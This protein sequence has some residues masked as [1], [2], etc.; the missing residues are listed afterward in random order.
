MVSITTAE[1]FDS[2]P[3]SQGIPIPS[4]RL[5]CMWA[6]FG[7]SPGRY[8][9][10]RMSSGAR[11][12]T[13]TKEERHFRKMSSSRCLSSSTWYAFPS[14]TRIVRHSILPPLSLGGWRNNR[15]TSHSK[16]TIINIS[17]ICIFKAEF[18][19]KLSNFK[20]SENI[21][22]NKFPFSTTTA[23]TEQQ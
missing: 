4:I 10:H 14:H 8:N 2:P 7:A 1:L 20:Q 19:H 11:G 6:Y 16:D 18:N 5:H 12:G 13:P 21:V 15:T 22:T 3:P 23:E 9:W 17:W